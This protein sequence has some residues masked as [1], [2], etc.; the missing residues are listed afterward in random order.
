[1]SIIAPAVTQN[2]LTLGTTYS[3]SKALELSFSYVHAFRYKQNGPTYIGGTGSL[4]MY[5]N[6]VGVSLGYKL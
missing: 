2:H 4:E 6:S 1:M 5:Q 3:P